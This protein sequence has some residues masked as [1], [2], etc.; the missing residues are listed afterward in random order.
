MNFKIAGE[1]V[2]KPKQL[3]RQVT[4][5]KFSLYIRFTHK[6]F[7]QTASYTTRKANKQIHVTN[8]VNK[9]VRIVERSTAFE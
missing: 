7:K 5:N 6:V 8:I 1:L 3:Q 4:D 2:V 9:I